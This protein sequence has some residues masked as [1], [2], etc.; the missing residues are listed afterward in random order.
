ML[1]VIVDHGTAQD[2]MRLTQATNVSNTFW[3]NG[4]FRRF[5]ANGVDAI[6]NPPRT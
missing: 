6:K 2:M 1:A 5:A 3:F 4:M